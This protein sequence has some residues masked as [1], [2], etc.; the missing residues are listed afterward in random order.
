MFNPYL[1]QLA[2]VPRWVN[3]PTIK[4]Q[5][6][7]QHTAFVAIYVAE[8]LELTHF[9]GTKKFECLRA[10]L[11]HD[12]VEARSGDV[13]GPYKRMI[14]DPIKYGQTESDLIHELGYESWLIDPDARLI[15]KAADQIDEYM[16][17]SSEIAFGN[18][19]LERLLRQ[20]ENRLYAA[21]RNASLFF[22]KKTFSEVYE[23]VLSSAADVE[24]FVPLEDNSDI[25]RPNQDEEFPF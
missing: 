17:L 14:R 22:G 2:R 6:V 25:S 19:M 12:M 9:D 5:D 4:V 16:F 18:K 8:L 7:A 24:N 21:L 23:E 3:V 11:A 20:S 1:R 15:I 13:S 10:A